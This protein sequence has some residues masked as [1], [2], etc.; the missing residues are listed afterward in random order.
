MVGYGILATL[1]RATLSRAMFE[2]LKIVAEV[3]PPRP[4]GH[5]SQEGILIERV[6]FLAIDSPQF[7]LIF[8]ECNWF[9]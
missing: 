7:Q 2:I 5:P 9:V 8:I 6:G 4:F 3:D 1:S